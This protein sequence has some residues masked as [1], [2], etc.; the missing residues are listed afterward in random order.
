[1]GTFT[2]PVASSEF[3]NGAVNDGTEVYQNDKYI[4]DTLNAG[5]LDSTNLSLS[6][7]YAWTGV[8]TY[9]VSNANTDNN[10]L[11]ISAVMAA[12]K[13]GQ[14]ISSSVAQ[15]NSAL[16]YNELTNSSSTVPNY[17]T[18]N[19]GTGSN[20]KA[21]NTNSA[22]CF[23]GNCSSTSNT[24]GVAKLTQAGTGPVVDATLRT[25]TGL[26]GILLS[27]KLTSATTI[28][29]TATETAISDLSITLPAN[30]LKVGTTI[31]GKAW[32]KMD[33]PGAGPATA[34]IYVK[35]GGTAGTILLDSGA[36]TPATSL[37]NSLICVDWT[38][39][40]LTTGGSGTIE[41]QGLLFWNSNTIPVCRGLG[42]GATGATNSGAITIDTTLSKDLIISFVWGSAVSGCNTV[43]RAGHVEILS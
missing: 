32:G 40:C 2:L 11:V 22:S 34:R 33:T 23:E 37:A 28:N 29:N 9:T 31:R 3:D 19:V 12:N 27:K 10:A 7:P 42:T 26:N 17:E 41:A 20:Y 39:T 6:S 15:T 16:I 13:Y 14:H 5:G 4:V 25:L 36:F 18:S 8:H 38:L 24:S 30:F 43:F 1:M 35:Y 21:T